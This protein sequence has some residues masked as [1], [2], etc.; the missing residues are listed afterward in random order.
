LFNSHPFADT[1]DVVESRKKNIA[2]VEAGSKADIIPIFAGNLYAAHSRQTM[3]EAIAKSLSIASATDAR[4]VIA[5]LRGMMTRT[6]SS[7]LVEVGQVPLLWILGDEDSHINHLEVVKNV[8]LPANAEVSVLNG[9]GHMGF[10][11]AE[12]VSAS[13]LMR[14]A[15][16]LWAF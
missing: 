15:S 7:A 16:K 8:A 12:E 5:D 3:P 11:E 9:T 13:I 4:T 2:L 14:F 10:V 6:S 1:A